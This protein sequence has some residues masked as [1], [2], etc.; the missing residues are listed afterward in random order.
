MFTSAIL[1][2]INSV[3]SVQRELAS[4]VQ[5]VAEFIFFSIARRKHLVYGLLFGFRDFFY[6]I[7]TFGSYVTNLS[8]FF[9]ILILNFF[10]LNIPLES[11]KEGVFLYL[12]REECKH[13]Q[14]RVYEN[15]TRK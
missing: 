2:N 14:R 9:S 10:F 3:T 12:A 8:G 13:L 5:K 4:V 11:T 15:G 6:D 7:S 1:K